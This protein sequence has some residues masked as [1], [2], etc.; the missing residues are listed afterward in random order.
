MTTNHERNRVTCRHVDGEYL[1][2]SH[3][4]DCRDR[5]CQGCE[6]CE[7][8]AA[9]NPT[10][11][12]KRSGCSGHLKPMQPQTC[13]RCIG[14]V[15]RALSQIEDLSALMLYAA[16]EASDEDSE[17]AMLAGPAADPEA[18]RHRY[19]SALAGRIP[20]LDGA[21]DRLGED[22]NQ[23]PVNVLGWWVLAFREDYDQPTGMVLT[24]SSSVAYLKATLDK[25]AQDPKQDWG[26]FTQE[27]YDCR[28]HL[29]LVLATARFTE[30]GTVCPACREAGAEKPPRLEKHYV[31]GDHTGASDFWA[32][33][34]HPKAHRW[35]EAAYRMRVADDYVEHAEALTVKDLAARLGVP[36]GTIKRWAGRTFLGTD[37][38]GEAIYGEPKLKP[39]GR[40]HDGRRLYMVEDVARLAE[41]RV[42]RGA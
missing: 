14:R 41:A 25:I 38:K 4:K 7:T 29:E 10:R 3:L 42:L 31:R 26:A 33:P 21:G 19:A 16:I 11:H 28:A 27:V 30:R 8:D 13:P 32:C 5:S 6:P 17:P 9:G 12:C 36:A 20:H 34:D 18:R 22:D 1:L 23:H 37:S 40:S 15:R 2:P 35:R 39:R 24:L